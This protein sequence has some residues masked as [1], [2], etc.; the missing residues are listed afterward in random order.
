MGRYTKFAR[1]KTCCTYF[2][3]S[4][5]CKRVQGHCCEC[6]INDLAWDKLREYEEAIEKYINEFNLWEND[7]KYEK[8]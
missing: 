4:E 5:E 7:M 8:E 3:W 1:G 6:R 2:G